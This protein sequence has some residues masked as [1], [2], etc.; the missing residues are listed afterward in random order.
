L[1]GELE[2]AILLLAVFFYLL[3]VGVEGKYCRRS[4]SVTHAVSRTPLDE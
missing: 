1:G 3:T 4:H 2:M